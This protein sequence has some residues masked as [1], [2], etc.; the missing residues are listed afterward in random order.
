MGV[1]VL[2]ALLIPLSACSARVDGRIA[3]GG[4]LSLTLEATLQPKM[5]TLMTTLSG[6]G[7]DA[8]V[9][10]APGIAASLRGAPGVGAVDLRNPSPR[11]L[12]GTILVADLNRFLTVPGPG[13]A[14]NRLRF[15]S[16]DTQD[17]GGSLAVRLDHAGAPELL[18]LL[19]PDVVDYL[20]V[21][22]APAA[23]GESLSRDEYLELV[24]SVY[25]AGIAAEMRSA[26]IEVALAVPGV[27][28]SVMAGTF[29]GRR[30]LLTVPLLD[31]LVLDRPFVYEIR[32]KG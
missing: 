23:T 11:G 9:L 31:I 19:S 8:V 2:L 29:S 5:A 28:Q 22:M 13:G 7:A 15:L 21:L 30:A 26:T 25:G 24:R 16:Y 17:S 20:S 6:N 12:A 27:I 10:D 3:E 18:A 4:T 14:K 32:W 1:F